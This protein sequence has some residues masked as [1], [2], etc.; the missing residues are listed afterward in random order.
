VPQSNGSAAPSSAPAAAVPL[1]AGVAQG[2][3]LK[4]LQRAVAFIVLLVVLLGGYFYFYASHQQSY[5]VARNL[6][7][8]ASISSQMAASLNSADQLLSLA[9]S[10]QKRPDLVG[11][12]VNDR[13]EHAAPYIPLYQH[14]ALRD[15]ASKAPFVGARARACLI[16]LAQL[17]T[18]PVG[19]TWRQLPG[20]R[21]SCRYRW[22]TF[23][24]T[25]QP[26][27]T[28]HGVAVLN[29]TTYLNE[30]FQQALDSKTFDKA[31]VADD[32]GRILVQAGDPDLALTRL[33]P[34]VRNAKPTAPKA[35]ADSNATWARLRLAPGIIDVDLAGSTYRLFLEPCCLSEGSP[36]NQQ[37]V[38]GGLIRKD[39]FL[40][41]SLKISLSVVTFLSALL[42]LAAVSWAFLKFRLIGE[43]HGV[44]LSDGLL[45]GW[46]SLFAAGLTTVF[47]LDLY[48][49][50]R[51]RADR[52]D[53]LRKLGQAIAA[54]AQKEITQAYDQLAVLASQHGKMADSGLGS[55]GKDTVRFP[56]FE[57]WGLVD[58]HGRQV[59]K[60]STDGFVQPLINV[61][62]REYF[63]EVLSGR[64][65]SPPESESRMPHPPAGSYYVESTLS[66]TTGK[67]QA[68]LAIRLDSITRPVA[69]MALEMVS[70]IGPV[71]P[72]GYGF[73]VIDDAGKVLFHSDQK[74]NL[75][76][77][78][79]AE[80]D[81]NRE[82]RSL[83]HAHSV[84]TLNMK[85][86]GSDFR[87]YVTPI[88]GMPWTVVAFRDKQAGRIT[89]AEWLATSVYL[90]MIYALILF[91]AVI[92]TL[93][94][95]PRYRAPWLWPDRRLR[96]SYLQ[97]LG[98]EGFFLAAFLLAL[99]L[100]D[101]DDLLQA[102]FLLPLVVIVAT[103]LCLTG[104]DHDRGSTQRAVRIAVALLA[105][106]VLAWRLVG[107]PTAGPIHLAIVVLAALGLDAAV[108]PMGSRASRG[109]PGIGTPYLSAGFM[110]LALIG[111][112]PGAAFFKVARSAYT[113]MLVKNG[114]MQV[115]QDLEQRWA[116]IQ[117]AYSDELG[118]GKTAARSA[119]LCQGPIRSDLCNLDLYFNAF[120]QTH[121][122][123]Q[124]SASGRADSVT[125][126]STSLVELF[127]FPYHPESSVDWRAMLRPTADSTAWSWELSASRLIHREPPPPGG[128]AISL[129]STIPD[130]RPG[131][132]DERLLFAGLFLVAVPFVLWRIVCFLARR[133]LLI[134]V[135]DP[136]VVT[137]P[138]RI[139][140]LGGTNLF[141]LCR[142]CDEENQMQ[143][144]SEAV[145]LDL[146]DRSVP[147]WGD[148]H[149]LGDRVSEGKLVLLRHFEWR[150]RD[151]VVANAKLR[152]LDALVQEY[153]CSVVAVSA[154]ERNTSPF[155][156]ASSWSAA[157]PKADQS[158]EHL[159]DTLASFVLVDA[160]RWCDTPSGQNRRREDAPRAKSSSV[161]CLISQEA[162]F[163]R[164]LSSIW[165]G[166][167]QSMETSLTHRAAPTEQELFDLLGERAAVYY[168][169]IWQTCLPAERA[170][171]VHLARS[172]LVN[173]KDRRTIRRLLARGLIRREPQ[174]RVMNETFRQYLLG[175]A[176]AFE[177][178]LP[179]GPRSTWDQV[180]RPIF[181]GVVSL[182][183]LLFVTQQELF[184]AVNAAFLAV[185]GGVASFVKVVGL[186]DGR[187]SGSSTA[188]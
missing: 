106:G 74:R 30:I 182:A 187:K 15:T 61:P 97:L 109:S 158:P 126:P 118:K 14:L 144:D 58:H 34:L 39:R 186:F 86:G 8:L 41:Q 77:Q 76:E 4:G 148:L 124:A 32:S 65:W 88:P 81:Q 50:Q 141:V 102:G 11:F 48:S 78:F 47:A 6:R 183:V 160:S 2:G 157:L 26:D 172:G 101:W 37:L 63:T 67:R 62:D 21:P 55:I 155:S 23:T 108:F 10:I 132:L 94:L 120:F 128:P 96:R 72:P 130:F 87:A 70:L 52:D 179:R 1:R 59:L 7:V 42:M 131:N 135:T 159:A 84:D 19:E 151:P 73:A 44:L 142:N 115:A 156:L 18:L 57:S 82:L 136:V 149:W 178:E 166:F 139:A 167:E 20:A 147:L 163:D 66:R 68:A 164:H 100:L 171:L 170:V 121:L 129:S 71:I 154:Q 116:R 104:P 146:K 5:L 114:Q 123:H 75:Q 185:S 125:A 175:H 31:L 28:L 36:W 113:E 173:E 33:D 17:D 176:A 35:G 69:S 184:S 43:G 177:V 110:F 127:L 46:S 60:Q 181:A 162:R 143:A 140:S 49:Y 105:L 103:V 152:L 16:P 165:S 98:V 79:F 134:D 22:F 38:V 56:F 153:R 51:F 91:A 45:L 99:L 111:A 27:S 64:G 83:I 85:Y 119:R 112:L 29:T 90:I 53:E 168:D 24:S 180:R 25:T 80:T 117:A 137:E 145:V 107:S 93:A 40:R 161:G 12:K 95:H 13:W 92:V 89:N 122:V 150:Q 169:G 3:A 138:R 133:V 174:F 188:A 9:D 54:N